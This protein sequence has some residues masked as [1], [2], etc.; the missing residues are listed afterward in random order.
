MSQ[1]MERYIKKHGKLKVWSETFKLHVVKTIVEQDLTYREASLQFNIRHSCTIGK[2]VRQ[3]RNEIAGSNTI[4]TMQQH[5]PT[6]QPDTSGAEQIRQL[7]QSLAEATLKITAL[8]TLIDQ[9]ETTYRIS[10]R[11]NFGT[12]QPDC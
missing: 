9:A 8:N 5:S 6:L 2:W 1:V 11:K 12:K 7:Q 4:G 3:Y 10:I